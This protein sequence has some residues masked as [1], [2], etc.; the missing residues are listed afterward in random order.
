[1]ISCAVERNSAIL[2]LHYYP[3]DLKQGGER[4]RAMVEST[5]VRLIDMG[6]THYNELANDGQTKNGR[7]W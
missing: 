3:S 6:H 7:K 1:M 5:A 2:L 4:L